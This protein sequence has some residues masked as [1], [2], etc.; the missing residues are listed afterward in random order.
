MARTKG[1]HANKSISF[2]PKIFH[3]NFQ[4]IQGHQDGSI[5]LRTIDPKLEVRKF[6]QN[7]VDNFDGLPVKQ[8]QWAHIPLGRI[9]SP[10]TT[11]IKLALQSY[12]FELIMKPQIKQLMVDT[13]SLVHEHQWYMESVSYLWQQSLRDK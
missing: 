2:F 3:L 13:I 10:I 7:I 6:R 1:T 11:E 5:I 8:S 9:L 4:C 12:C